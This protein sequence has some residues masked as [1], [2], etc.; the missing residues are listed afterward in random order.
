MTRP[1][2]QTDKDKGL[3]TTDSECV[4]YLKLK[5]MMRALTKASESQTVDVD[6][7][8]SVLIYPSFS[9]FDEIIANEYHE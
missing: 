3:K 2:T 6:S 7:S 1:M 9:S 4:S 8:P 5:E